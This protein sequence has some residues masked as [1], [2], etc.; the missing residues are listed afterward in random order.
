MSK[1]NTWLDYANLASNVAQNVQLLQIVNRLD[2][3]LSLAASAAEGEAQQKSRRDW[4]WGLKSSLANILESDGAPTQKA[5]L[6]LK[7]IKLAEGGDASLFD[8]WED[9][10]RLA[11]VQSAARQALKQI[12]EILGAA[13]MSSLKNAFQLATEELPALRDQINLELALEDQTRHQEQLRSALQDV[14]SQ[15]ES[16]KTSPPLLGRWRRGTLLSK[17]RSRL[18]A[19]LATTTRDI[20]GKR[21]MITEKPSQRP[22]SVPVLM[23]QFQACAR[24]CVEAIGPGT[25]EVVGLVFGKGLYFPRGD[26][27]TLVK[28][29]RRAAERG[30]AS[31]Q[32]FFGFLCAQGL[33]MTKNIVE[34]SKWLK[35]AAEKG[36]AEAIS[37]LIDWYSAGEYVEQDFGEAMK[38]ALIAAEQLNDADAQRIL[39]LWYSSG[40]GVALDAVKAAGWFQKAAAQG[41]A[42]AQCLLAICYRDGRG[43]Q[44]DPT[45]MVEWLQK[46]A[47]RGHVAAQFA[48]AGCYQDGSGVTKDIVAATAWYR[49]AAENG[50]QEAWGPLAMLCLINGNRSEM[51]AAL[52]K[53]IVFHRKQ[54]EASPED[55]H[56]YVNLSFYSVLGGQP[57]QAECVAD[58]GLSTRNIDLPTTEALRLNLGHALL[59]QGRMQEAM[60]IYRKCPKEVIDEDFNILRLALPDQGRVIDLV[61]AGQ[62]SSKNP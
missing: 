4:L 51:E 30:D 14:D 32:I 22:T 24:R 29:V 46:A 16:L 40:H 8:S 11:E 55:A 28:W 15:K 9:K 19:E 18:A 36:D 39:G 57:K 10:E 45:K 50:K 41:D 3:G 13:R 33:G 60:E 17:R 5:Y 43:V 27:E 38:W 2:T 49:K 54:I 44:V 59:M 35:K 37:V 20:E 52:D 42:T 53:A 58:R 12:G 31:A 56:N 47:E 23:E 1:G 25:E 21:R 62:L 34:A 61:E 6:L 7:L 26:A 48:L